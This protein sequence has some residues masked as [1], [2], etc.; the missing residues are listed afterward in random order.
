M[1]AQ[2]DAFMELMKRRIILAAFLGVLV[3]FVVG[4][5]PWIQPPNAPRAQLLMQQAGQTNVVPPTF[6]PNPS[7]GPAPLL[8]AILAGLAIASPVFLLARRKAR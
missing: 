7:L 1:L 2:V 5:S 3:G 8:I 6:Q 4:Y